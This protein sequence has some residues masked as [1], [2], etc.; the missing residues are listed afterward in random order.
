MRIFASICV[1]QPSGKVAAPSVDSLTG[2]VSRR[3]MKSNVGIGV[4]YQLM[5]QFRASLDDEERE[6]VCMI[7]EKF[8]LSPEFESQLRLHDHELVFL[9]SLV[10]SEIHVVSTLGCSIIRN[11]CNLTSFLS[12]LSENEI[13][14][15]AMVQF[16]EDDDVRSHHVLQTLVQ[17]I[18]IG[19][20]RQ[21]SIFDD[22]RVLKSIVRLLGCRKR[23]FRELS[24]RLLLSLSDGDDLGPRDSII[25]KSAPLHDLVAI[26]KDTPFIESK[27]PILLLSKLCLFPESQL[28]LHREIGFI[29]E[30]A[31][32]ITQ[33]RGTDLSSTKSQ[34]ALAALCCIARITRDFG[35]PPPSYPVPIYT[36]P[37]DG[38]RRLSEV[39]SFTNDARFCSQSRS[40]IREI[41]SCSQILCSAKECIDVS[42]ET[43]T[44]DSCKYAFINYAMEI[45]YNM[46]KIETSHQEMLDPRHQLLPLWCKFFDHIPLPGCAVQESTPT[47]HLQFAL[48]ILGNLI[49][50]R[51]YPL[52]PFTVYSM[53][54]SFFSHLE[55]LLN[56]FCLAIDDPNVGIPSLKILTLSTLQLFIEDRRTLS[57]LIESEATQATSLVVFLCKHLSRKRSNLPYTDRFIE[58]ML[59]MLFT[60]TSSTEH[61][62]VLMKCIS[63]TGRDVLLDYM[64]QASET[65]ITMLA[66]KSLLN[67]SRCSDKE[68]ITELS[69]SGGTKILTEWLLRYVFLKPS[70]SLSEMHISIL[71]LFN[72][73]HLMAA[74]PPTKAFLLHRDEKEYR[75]KVCASS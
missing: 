23:E 11:A 26:I 33:G 74:D 44:V 5:Q 30:M 31:M 27:T 22:S 70:A 38:P 45:F 1:V 19:N 42:I 52:E 20:F 50:S 15:S 9:S 62:P 72:L 51:T 32:K 68:S 48:L 16:I 60:L 7:L 25:M 63:C 61:L 66:L 28:F 14:L 17:L 57:L 13:L 58:S 4:F 2:D 59:N 56:R 65:S 35:T 46:S 47:F 39:T 43:E 41:F 6:H 18:C 40:Y 54:K 8:S 69:G 67:M 34:I 49:Q 75:D 73:R 24:C 21:I 36:I 10:Q 64:R 12:K 71:T 53:N 3:V 55:V 37:N 29:R